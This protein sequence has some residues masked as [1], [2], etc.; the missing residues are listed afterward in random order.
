M[1][2]TLSDILWLLNEVLVVVQLARLW[3]EIC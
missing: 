2:L 3:L 1:C